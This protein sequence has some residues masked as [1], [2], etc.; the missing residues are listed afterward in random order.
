MSSPGSVRSLARLRPLASTYAYYAAFIGLGLIS[1]SLGPTL[2]GLAE[3]TRSDLGQISGLFLARSTGYMVGSFVGGRFYDRIPGNP[4]MAGALLVM[5][6]GMTA[7]PLLPTLWVLAAV[8]FG[9]GLGEGTVDVGG[10]TLLVWIHR[11]RVGP[12]MNALHFMFGLGAFLS[13]LVIAQAVIWSG[14]IQLGYWMLAVYVLPLI[15]WLAREPSPIS[16]V[17]QDRT[18]A[19]RIHVNWP[20]V[21]LI[22]LFMFLYVGAEVGFG[23]WVYTYALNM[24]LADETSAFFLTSLFWGALTLGRL[25][26]IPITARL[27]PR[28]VLLADMVGAL[29]S[30]ALLLA[31]PTSRWAL[32]VGIFGAGLSLATVF[33]TVITWAERRITLS[34]LVTSIFLVGASL[35]AMFLPWLIGQLFEGRGPQITMISIL[36]DLMAA[37]LIYVLLMVVGGQPTREER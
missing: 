31:L 19:I 18:A 1:A 8:L 23:G 32:W 27:R 5:A 22:A 37:A 11:S 15:I 20:L 36:I 10:N 6:L 16:E 25:L 34:G 14:G 13:P 28:T 33:P 2:P 7:A 21:G 35:G 9:V 12:Y 29:A 17:E 3:Q 30:V 24:G 26:S 4:V